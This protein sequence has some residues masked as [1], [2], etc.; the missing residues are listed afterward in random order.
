MNNTILPPWCEQSRTSHVCLYENN[1]VFFRLELDTSLNRKFSL[2]K[3]ETTS[4]P[5]NSVN[6]L[7]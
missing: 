4:L 3:S 6:S 2:R 1:F 7:I 5:R